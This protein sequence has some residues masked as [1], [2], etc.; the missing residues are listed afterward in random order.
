MPYVQA[1][2][3]FRDNIRAH[4]RSGEPPDAKK[5]LLLCD[6][7]RDQ[8]LV[9][10]GIA[11]EDREGSALIK[12]ID[13]DTLLAERAA[14]AAAQAKKASEAAKKTMEKLL[15]GK[16]SPAEHFKAS[17]FYAQFDNDG[18]PTHDLAQ[19]RVSKSAAKKIRKEWDGQAKA[20]ANYLKA[21]AAGLI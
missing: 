3:T 1:L 21:Q 14:K 11:M 6:T 17:G 15:K 18:L 2:S 16:L 12:F 9:E 5:L 20:H 4:L 7:L 19:E 13:H 10:L 8:D